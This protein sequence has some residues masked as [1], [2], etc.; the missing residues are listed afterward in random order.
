[1]ST[2]PTLDA[3]TPEE[4]ER[5]LR[6]ALSKN[7][8][9]RAIA[10]LTPADR[11]LLVK[12]GYAKKT[13]EGVHTTWTPTAAGARLLAQADVIYRTSHADST[14]AG[15]GVVQVL[16]TVERAKTIRQALSY[17]A[18]NKPEFEALMDLAKELD[19]AIAKASD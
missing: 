17:A 2:S 8:P 11:N 1:M 3:L 4:A 10:R 6:A 7:P 12:H 18:Q 16:V 9:A 15:P 5:Y 13:G 14:D 19:T